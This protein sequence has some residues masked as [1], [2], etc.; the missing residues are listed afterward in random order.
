MRSRGLFATFLRPNPLHSA[1]AVCEI[2]TR[3]QA[4]TQACLD[5]EGRRFDDDNIDRSA[6]VRIEEPHAGR[7]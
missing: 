3:S 6:S 4:V 5:A 7:C 2:I 1:D